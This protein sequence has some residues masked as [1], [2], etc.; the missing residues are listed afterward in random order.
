MPKHTDRHYRVLVV[1]SRDQFDSYIADTMPS[2]MNLTADIKRNASTARRMLLEH[3]YDIVIINAPLSDETGLELALDI[4]DKS[5][6]QV[7]LVTP[8]E[9]FDEVLDRVTDYGVLVMPDG[10]A[11]SRMEKILRY[12][13]AESNKIK[14]LKKQISDTQDKMEQMRLVNKAKFM[15]VEQKHISEDEAHRL[16]GKLAMD[17][18]ISRGKAARMV[19]DDLE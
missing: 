7:L 5:S 4:V 15:L 11:V 16:I 3:E 6:C 8:Q 14:D 1:S 19:I 12:I 2:G 9:V 18:G 10:S 13:I 17:N